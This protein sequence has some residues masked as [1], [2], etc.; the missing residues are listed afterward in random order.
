MKEIQSWL[1]HSTQESAQVAKELSTRFVAHDV[2]LMEG[3]L[4]SGKTWLVQN[5]CANWHVEDEVTSPTF[6]LIQN[7]NGS[8]PINH[9][10]L[11]RIEDPAELDQLGWEEL[12]YTPSVSFIEW[13]SM[14][15]PYISN[16][17][18]I[19]IEFESEGRRIKLFKKG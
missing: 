10:D 18:K 7:Y 15:E 17:Y 6:T 8:V 12:I 3:T 13:P 5:I 14:V 19:V 16:Y 9:M 11:Y 1:V 2:V 4:G